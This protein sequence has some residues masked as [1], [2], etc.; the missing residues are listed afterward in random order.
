MKSRAKIKR[1]ALA[2]PAG[3]TFVERI[4]KGVF[5]YAS[6]R[7]RWSFVRVPERLD[8]GLEWLRNS[9]CDGAFVMI[10]DEQAAKIA[11]SL[12]MPVVNLSAYVEIPDLPTVMVDQKET[13]R[14]AARHLLDRG[15]TRFAYY[16]TSDLWYSRVRREGFAETILAAGGECRVLEVRSATHASD[17]W[18]QQEKL[19]A[20]LGKMVER[21]G[22]MASTDLRAC[23]AADACAQLGLRVPED[24]FGWVCAHRC[25]CTTVTDTEIVCSSWS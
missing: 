19:E 7:G 21:T 14:M 10:S 18:K 24:S 13:A 8:M 20:W 3:I 15:F 2:L 6:K 25:T 4:L 22:I 16:G 5:D 12:P 1:I 17:R 11:R 9:G 23:M